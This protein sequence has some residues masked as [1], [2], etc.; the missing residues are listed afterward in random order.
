MTVVVEFYSLGDKRYDRSNAFLSAHYHSNSTHVQS[1]VA[2]QQTIMQLYQLLQNHL[3][4]PEDTI[5]SA[6]REQKGHS[7]QLDGVLVYWQ[8]GIVS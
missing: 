6:Q 5:R 4:A 8:L 2:K 7:M 3:Y 1:L